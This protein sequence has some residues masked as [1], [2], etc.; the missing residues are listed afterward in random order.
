M[1]EYLCDFRHTA[2]LAASPIVAWTING[3]ENYVGSLPWRDRRSAPG[4][5]QQIQRQG[6]PH[7][8]AQCLWRPERRTYAAVW[9]QRSGPAWVAV[10]GVDT[11]G[12]QTFFNNWTAKG[13]VPVLVSATGAVS[14]AIFGDGLQKGRNFPNSPHPDGRKPSAAQGT[15]GT[16][17]AEQVAGPVPA[18]QLLPLRPGRSVARSGTGR[19]VRLRLPAADFASR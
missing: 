2:T 7:H 6:L 5:L 19:A 12:Y 17:P 14:D 11:A 18:C 4:E 13:F 9:V 16:R 15:T 10:H 3:R 1:A 8:L